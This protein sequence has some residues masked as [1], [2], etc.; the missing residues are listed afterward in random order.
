M[1]P[2]SGCLKVRRALINKTPKR[3]AK[4]LARLLLPTVTTAADVIRV[5]RTW[6]GVPFRHQGRDRNG[7]DCWGVPVVVLRELGALPEGF[8]EAG[9][10]RQPLSGQIQKHLLRFCTVLPD[11]V[12]GCLVALRMQSTAMHVAIFTDTDT[13]IHAMDRQSRGG[14][15]EHGFR[16]MWRSRYA[17][18]AWALPGVRYG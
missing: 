7:I 10:P 14:V 6:V 5:A 2:C 4:P 12:P 13:I 18:G 16:G 9:Y 17:Q 1:S 11:Y 8:D 15:V 3:I